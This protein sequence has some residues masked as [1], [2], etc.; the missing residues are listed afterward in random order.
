MAAAGTE[1]LIIDS[2][3]DLA[4]NA[5]SWNRDLTRS[6]AEIRANESW[7]R[8]DDARGHCTTS[9]PELR[10][11]GVAVC[12]GTVLVRAKSH[13][14]PETG[15]RRIDLDVAN[16]QIAYAHGQGQ[17]AY[18]RL[19]NDAGEIQLIRDR[20]GLQKHWAHWKESDAAERGSLPVGV[21]LAM[22]G[23]DPIVS[24]SQAEQWWRDGLRCVGLA[25]YGKSCYA[26][27]TG[28][29]GPLTA[30]GIE[31]LREFERL[32]MILDLTHASDPSF[33]QAAE[34]FHGPIMAS[35]NNCRDLVPGDRQFSDEQIQ[36][37]VQRQ[38][39]IGCALDA[40]MLKP[41]FVI[42]Q[43]SG[44][45][46]LLSNLIDHIDH[47]CQLAGN[48]HHVAIGSDLDGGF[49]TEQTPNG[50]ETI[51]DLQKLGDLL[52]DRGYDDKDINC[53]FHGNWLRFL[54]MSL[55]DMDL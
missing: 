33:F 5:L 2:H 19:L 41:N 13:V 50:L 6:V 31:L 16:Q 24:P 40:W 52:M 44:S 4:W 45:E 3:L 26:V 37:I 35:H 51:A 29:S 36:L 47:I 22:E 32:G 14:Q 55:P 9:L 46:V 43:T 12:L 7:M 27:G 18:Y 53:I 8:D 23:A 20:T 38:G 17:L 48:C 10:R 34:L 30:A 11:A 28:D 54:S 15:H 39:V 42:G 25:H 21:V 49:G 1:R